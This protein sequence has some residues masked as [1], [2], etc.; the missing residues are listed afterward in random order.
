MS[1][2]TAICGGRNQASRRQ[3]SF[4]ALTFHVPRNILWSDCQ[5]ACLAQFLV[6][7]CSV[8]SSVNSLMR[9]AICRL[10]QSSRI[11]RLFTATSGIPTPAAHPSVPCGWTLCPR[12]PEPA[13]SA[14]P[15]TSG[16]VNRQRPPGP[17]RQIILGTQKTGNPGTGSE[18]MVRLLWRSPHKDRHRLT[19]ALPTTKR[20]GVMKRH[21]EI[22]ERTRALPRWLALQVDDILW[23]CNA[24]ETP[25]PSGA[26]RMMTDGCPGPHIVSETAS[27][28]VSS[29][30]T[31]GTPFCRRRSESHRIWFRRRC[32]FRCS[33]RGN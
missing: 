31:N 24:M 23:R 33:K 13:P 9:F 20:P 6:S 5:N 30:P 14:S 12:P 16:G 10:I 29:R 11:M 32:L 2:D 15:M 19:M 8:F 21:S 1:G 17:F 4:L 3:F 22:K 26:T 27:A 28:V 25:L 7:Y 18:S